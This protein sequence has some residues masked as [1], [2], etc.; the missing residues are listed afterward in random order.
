MLDAKSTLLF[1]TNEV[2]FSVTSTPPQNWTYVAEG[3]A[4]AVFKYIGNDGSIFHDTVLR[5]SKLRDPPKHDDSVASQLVSFQHNVIEKLVPPRYLPVLRVVVVER[6]WLEELIGL[7]NER[8][9]AERRSQQIDASATT[10]VV[11]T[12]LIGNQ[13]ITIE[14]KVRFMVYLPRYPAYAPISNCKPKWGFLPTGQ[15]TCRFC[16]HSA[17]RKQRTTYC[18]LDLYSED[19][20]RVRRALRSLYDLWVESD[21]QTNNLRIFHRRTNFHPGGSNTPMASIISKDSFVDE[22]APVLLNS[23]VLRLLGNLQRALGTPPIAALKAKWRLVEVDLPL[24]SE[25]REPTLDEWHNIIEHHVDDTSLR[26][27]DLRS[28]CMRQSLSGTFKDCSIMIRPHLYNRSGPTSNLTAF[29]TG[30]DEQPA[31]NAV[32]IIDL[33]IKPLSRLAKWALLD[34]EIKEA[35][36]ATDQSEQKRCCDPQVRS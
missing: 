31:C 8:R 34:E 36:A 33:D 9:P 22:I 16:M 32:T 1:G 14:I 30:E 35:Y 11:A 29:H 13:Q 7:Q 2:N 23:P 27:L 17:V 26:S 24:G 4:T 15:M 12:N 21:G 19:E 25:M 10:A 20:V 28:L 6:W 5:L 3:G 18:P